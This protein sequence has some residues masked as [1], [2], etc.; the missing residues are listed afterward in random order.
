MVP[1]QAADRYERKRRTA[2]IPENAQHL[3][4][5]SL[6][7]IEIDHRTVRFIARIDGDLFFFYLKL[8]HI[9]LP[10]SLITVSIIMIIEHRSQKSNAFRPVKDHSVYPFL[11]PDSPFLSDRIVHAVLHRQYFLHR[12]ALEYRHFHL[13]FN[14]EEGIH[15]Q[16]QE[17][18]PGHQP[19]HVPLHRIG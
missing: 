1:L 16:D 19:D 10:A 18:D 3:L 12:N 7:S 4:P 14:P 6:E 15:C 13:I 2:F 5:F 8:S 9:C 11:L 17:S